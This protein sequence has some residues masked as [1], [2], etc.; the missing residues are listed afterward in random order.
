MAAPEDDGRQH[1]QDGSDHPEQQLQGAQVALRVEQ[2]GSGLG[3]PQ[4]RDGSQ[5]DPLGPVGPARRVESR[6]GDGGQD[7]DDGDAGQAQHGELAQGVQG[8]ELDQDDVDQVVTAGHLRALGEVVLG[9]P[10]ALPATGQQPGGQARGDAEAAGQDEGA[11]APADVRAPEA[12]REL[13]QHQHDHHHGQ[14]LDHQLGQAH[15]GRAQREQLDGDGDPHAAEGHGG[16]DPGVG[17]A[18]RDDTER[19]EDEQPDVDGSPQVGLRRGHVADAEDREAADPEDE[20]Q[21]DERRD[22]VA[23]RV[24]GGDRPGD[25]AARVSCGGED[26][27]ERVGAGAG[28]QVDLEPAVERPAPRHQRGADHDH[29]GADEE[30]GSQP[31]PQL[32]LVRRLRAH[33]LD[34]ALDRDVEDPH[35]EPER[36]AGPDRGRGGQEQPGAGTMAGLGP[37][38]VDEPPEHDLGAVGD[39]Q[40]RP[41]PGGSQGEDPHPGGAGGLQHRAEDRLLAHEAEHRRDP[42]HARGAEDDGREA[43]RHHAS[44]LGQTADVAGAGGVVD[45]TDHHEE[46]GLEQRVGDRVDHGGGQR[47]LGADTDGRGDQPQLAHRGVGHQPLEVVLLEGEERRHRGG[48]ETHADQQRVPDRHLGERLGEAQHQVDAGLDHRG[49]VQVGADRGGGG[50]RVGEPGVEGELRSLGEAGHGDQDRDHRGEAGALG[51]HVGGQRLRERRRTGG[52]DHQHDG[53]Q[54]GEPTEEGHEQR[55]GRRRLGSGARSGDQQEGGQGGDLPAREQQDQVVGQDEADHAEGEDGHPQVEAEL[56]SL[57]EVL[58]G[59]DEDRCADEQRD[60][61]EDQAEPVHA[62][63]QVDVEGGQPGGRPGDLATV[64]DLSRG[65]DH[66]GREGEEAEG[67]RPSRSAAQC[68]GQRDHED[69]DRRKSD[70]Q[71]HQCH[72]GP[73]LGRAEHLRTS[74]ASPAL[75]RVML[76]GRPSLAMAGEARRGGDRALGGCRSPPA[77]RDR[78]VVELRGFEPLTFSLRTR[79]ATNCATA[80]SRPK[81]LEKR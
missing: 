1:E 46:P 18:R 80:P 50:H 37:L 51:P 49:R 38:P 15:V 47:L 72:R 12:A 78:R 10:G 42:G 70:Q 25:P 31:V 68:T 19:D 74:R 9:R 73:F 54:Q 41:E 79:R 69:G 8:P 66:R 43:P 48:E 56:T 63:R 28:Q 2:R 64:E 52:H 67:Q 65:R 34:G 26:P 13:A 76:V 3:V 77:W 33:R 39:G 17:Q 16:S 24:V 11:T 60:H 5:R 21:H 14:H 62:Q 75:S 30:L 58:H 29:G 36:Q 57:S 20:G 6:P 22:H 40:D 59:V 61:H 23:T 35:G 27:L 81:T 4:R 55:A 44:Q 32:Q 71:P 53:Q 7:G 45:D